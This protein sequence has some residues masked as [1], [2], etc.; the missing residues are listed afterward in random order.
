MRFYHLVLLMLLGLLST[1]TMTLINIAF[2]LGETVKISMIGYSEILFAYLVD[3][4]IYDE[5]VV[6]ENIIGGILLAISLIW[7]LFK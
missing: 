6:L 3:I 4:L 5:T 2:L 7:I 1:I